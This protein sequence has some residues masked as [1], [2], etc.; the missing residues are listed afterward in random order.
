V[1]KERLKGIITPLLNVILSKL[2]YTS[3]ANSRVLS[4]KF[5]R[6]SNV[7]DLSFVPDEM[8]FDEEY[9]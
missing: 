4:L 6:S 9:R 8:A 1:F 7:F 3:P 2:L 5:E